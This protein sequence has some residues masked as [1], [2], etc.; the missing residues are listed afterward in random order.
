MAEIFFH[1]EK[2][3][4]LERINIDITK[5]YSKFPINK[6]YNPKINQLNVISNYFHNLYYSK[7]IPLRIRTYLW[8]LFRETHLDLY[9]YKEF[10]T[11]WKN[12]L[13]LRYFKDL[14]DFLFLRSLTRIQFPN[15]KLEDTNDPYIHL[16]AWQKPYTIRQ[17]LAQVTKGAFT[18]EYKILKIIKRNMRKITNLLE[19][20]CGTAP[21]ITSLFEFL[22]F[23]KRIKI[24]L[25]DIQTFPFHFAVYKFKNCANVI[26]ILL[27]PEND[28]SLNLSEKLDVIFCLTVFEHLNKP[29]ETVK[30]FYNLLNPE[31]LLF[32][33]FINTSG[34]GLDTMHSVRER[35]K[36]LDFICNNFKIIDGK[37]LKEK[38]VGLTVVKKM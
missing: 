9:W 10:E 20:G 4:I 12:I 8:R 23:P 22:K 25:C 30:T 35:E 11:Y 29:I 6:K 17:L 5:I 18:Y 15:S 34:D 27:S 38:N 3:G 31:G 16:D 2:S 28:F 24:F 21:V 26:P 36:V 7:I 32:F 19:F 37:I 13:G 33:D 1:S 14:N